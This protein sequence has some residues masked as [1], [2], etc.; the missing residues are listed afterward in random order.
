M[1]GTTERNPLREYVALTRPFTLLAPTIGFL[2]GAAIA[3]RGLPPAAAYVG[4]LSAALLNAA[5]NII[6][7]YFDLEI[8]RINKPNR[9]LPSGSVSIRNAWIFDAALYAASFVTAALVNREFLLI[10]LFTAFVTYAYSGPPFR[11][12]RWG[13]LANITIAI[14]RGCLLMVA[15]WTSTRPDTMWSAE[16]WF[17]GMIFGLYVVGAATTKDFSDMEGDAQGGCRTLPIVFGVE[18]SAK[19]IAPFF[20]F[21]FLLM[22]VGAATGVLSG[23][24]AVLTAAGVLLAAWGVYVAYLVLRHPEELT[25]E[26]NHV[27]W[28]HMYL[29]M[30][31]GQ[32]AF[33]VAYLV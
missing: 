33:A 24:R 2:S 18:R 30:V 27:S 12:K 21:P 19:I 17:V 8:D 6:N 20:V 4:A 5:S 22:A 26:A 23:S 7:Q 25:L 32:I 1:T 31:A 3:A 16:P 9:P 10:V 29:M 11:T 14:P 13:V 15:G 28:K